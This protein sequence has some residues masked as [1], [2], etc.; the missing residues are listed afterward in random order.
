MSNRFKLCD[1]DGL[2]SYVETFVTRQIVRDQLAVLNIRSETIKRFGS[3]L[4]SDEAGPFFLLDL[5]MVNSVIE[6]FLE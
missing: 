2:I 1:H 6:N 3:S 4:D 5:N